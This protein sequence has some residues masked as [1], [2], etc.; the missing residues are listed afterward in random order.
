MSV[1]EGAAWNARELAPADMP[2]YELE[3]DTVIYRALPSVGL[4]LRSDHLG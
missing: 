4:L 2:L 3:K 1:R